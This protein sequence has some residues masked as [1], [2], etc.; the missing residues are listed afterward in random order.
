MALAFTG[1]EAAMSDLPERWASLLSGATRGRGPVGAV[2]VGAAIPEIGDAAICMEGLVSAAEEFSLY[3]TVS[4]AWQL[5]GAP[6][7]GL[8]AIAPL[9]WWAEDDRG[10]HYLGTV[11]HGMRVAPGDVAEGSIRFWPA[12]DRRATE[13]RILP[14]TETHVAVCTV[15]LSPWNTPG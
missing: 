11:S 13:L 3:L 4:P 5:T 12:L 1:H 8:E 2:A 7:D 6:F 9:S 15:S 14:A 10:N